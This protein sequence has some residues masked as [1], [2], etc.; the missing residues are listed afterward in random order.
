MLAAG[1]DSPRSSEVALSIHHTV[2][3]VEWYDLG[4]AGDG[5]WHEGASLPT[6]RAGNALAVDT[7][8]G[9]VI[10]VDARGRLLG[11]S[12]AAGVPAGAYG[13]RPEIAEALREDG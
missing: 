13:S 8:G 6:P 12:A 9:R 11:D 2:A 1:R 5:A 4:P 7:V 10:V 3:P